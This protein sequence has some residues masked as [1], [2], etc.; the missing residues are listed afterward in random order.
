MNRYRYTSKFE[1]PTFVYPI[2]I[3]S[4]IK[5]TE[6]HMVKHRVGRIAE[7]REIEKKCI[8][9][10]MADIGDRWEVEWDET[11]QSLKNPIGPHPYKGIV[12][13]E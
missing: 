5:L 4:R 6:K 10:I 9:V 7:D 8:G 3:G 1:R 13:H 2:G 11:N 12:E